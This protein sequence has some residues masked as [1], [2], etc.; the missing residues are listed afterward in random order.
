MDLV[1]NRQQI[2]RWLQELIVEVG[3]EY[4]PKLVLRHITINDRQQDVA[5]FAPQKMGDDEGVFG[6]LVR[7]V[8]EAIDRDAEGLGGVQRYLLVATADD[9][10]VGRLPLRSSATGGI[11]G[12]GSPIESEP[13]TSRGQVAQQMRHN[14]ALMRMFVVGMGQVVSTMQRTIV[15]LQ[16]SADLAD[17][18]RLEAVEIAER[19]LSEENDRTLATDKA[20]H[21]KE[22]QS[23]GLSTFLTFASL[24]AGALFNRSGG[25]FIKQLKDLVESF[26]PKQI[27]RLI[28]L[29]RPE[30]VARLQELF[31]AKQIEDPRDPEKLAAAAAAL[32]GGAT[33]PVTG[34]SDS[35]ETKGGAP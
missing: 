12:D 34:D 1:S 18:R 33:A 5:N 31:T 26:D 23:K 28:E 17:E 25:Q 29:L 2:A 10:I 32:S 20:R 7:R 8:G 9:R 14:E 24:A 4:T 19:L 13:P 11:D 15:R 21:D 6:E 35:A 27:D 16:Q 22:I 3:D 30:Q